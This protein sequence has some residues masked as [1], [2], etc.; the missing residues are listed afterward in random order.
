MTVRNP[1]N[2]LLKIQKS[3]ILTRIESVEIGYYEAYTGLIRKKL[4]ELIIFYRCLYDVHRLK[5]S[6]RFDQS[7]WTV[8]IKLIINPLWSNLT[9]ETSKL[10]V[11]ALARILARPEIKILFSSPLYSPWKILNFDLL[12]GSN[13][14]I[15]TNWQPL[16][17]YASFAGCQ[18]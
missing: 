7:H 1:E 6:I 4:Y 5:F 13:R 14:W 10:V 16:T 15:L 11:Y 8:D 12:G 18:L 3:N 2:L 17:D 9:L